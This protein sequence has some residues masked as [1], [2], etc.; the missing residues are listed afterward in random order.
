MYLKFLYSVWKFKVIKER[1]QIFQKNDQA[2]HL[3]FWDSYV[4]LGGMRY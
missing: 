3:G 1:M 2:K 4:V